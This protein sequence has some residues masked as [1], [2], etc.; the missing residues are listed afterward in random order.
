MRVSTRI[1]DIIKQR[2]VALGPRN[3]GKSV[4]WKLEGD[5]WD[6]EGL[7]SD[8]TRG[9]YLLCRVLDG[10]RPLGWK[11]VGLYCLKNFSRFILIFFSI[12]ISSQVSSAD[13]SSKNVDG[14]ERGNALVG[15]PEDV[16]TWFFLYD[17]SM[18]RAAFPLVNE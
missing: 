6:S 3:Y 14:N 10:I 1:N 7:Y 18:R 17:V 5:P 4:E 2:W 12:Y 8:H 11:L 15:K 16:H 13:I 9:I